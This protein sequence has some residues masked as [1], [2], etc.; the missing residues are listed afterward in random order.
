MSLYEMVADK[1]ASWDTCLSSGLKSFLNFVM[2]D[3]IRL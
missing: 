1:I 3:S 2:F